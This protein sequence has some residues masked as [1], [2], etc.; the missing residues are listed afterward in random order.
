M[1]DCMD[2]APETPLMPQPGDIVDGRYSVDE[3][4]A[5][6]GMSTVFRATHLLLARH[7]CLKVLSSESVSRPEI[8]AQ[9]LQ[10]GRAASQLKSRHAVEVFDV[11][12]VAAGA[13][14]L[15]MEWLE[16]S[17][18][19]DASEREKL[20]IA[21]VVDYVLQACEAL[22]EVHARGVVTSSRRTSS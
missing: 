10:E 11:G 20:P 17:D 9:F 18:L 12:T 5:V 19:A 1:D 16:G 14:Y 13:P 2:T 22:A 7:V 4:V 3:L 6:G 21:T 15:A 8:V